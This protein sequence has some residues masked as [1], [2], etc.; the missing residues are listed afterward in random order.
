MLL[1]PLRTDSP[2]RRRPTANHVLIALNFLIF[3]GTHD[4][5]P[6]FLRNEPGM[7]EMRHGPLRSDLIEYRL[8][9]NG[10]N[11]ELYQLFTYQFLH[12]GWSHLLGNLLFLWVF[13]NSVNAKMGQV[14]YL[15]FYLSCGV[16]AGTAYITINDAALLGASGAI[17]GVTTGFL[18]LFPRSRTSF[19]YWFFVIGYF[20]LPSMILIVAKIIVYDNII[21]PMLGGWSS[22]AYSAHIAGY[23]AGLG[24]GMLLL[25]I[26]AIPRDQF[27][28]VALWKR[29]LQRRAFARAVATDPMSDVRARYGRVARTDP[30]ARS[31]SAG[32]ID[33]QLDETM[34]IRG[35]ITAAIHAGDRPAA[36]DGYL[37]LIEVNP[38]LV[39][40]R[41]QQ[42]DVGNAL[43][44][45]QKYVEAAE[46]YEKY[47]SHYTTGEHRQQVHL[48]LGVIYA[49]YLSS[50]EQAEAHL[51]RCKEMLSDGQMLDQ[52]NEWLAVA[53]R[54]LGRTPPQA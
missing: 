2:I 49:K 20:E 11:P 50:Y 21:E 41:Q 45:Q 12:D 15:L 24:I 6:L 44:G 51:L 10:D 39:L 52:C 17:A 28:L 46:A 42:L 48:M 7:E 1:I 8:M 36:A 38:K 54:E 34:D 16:L 35:E 18:V 29:A 53:A 30:P 23:A 31:G 47:L 5:S 9:L 40:P 14:T 33:L 37:R 32:E 26:R 4:F 13:G 43:M 3:L 22:V 27:D 25:W 19:F